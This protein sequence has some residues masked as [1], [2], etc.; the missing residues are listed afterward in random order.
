[1]IGTAPLVAG[2]VLLGTV[3]VGLVVHEWAHAAVLRL[4]GI[5]YDVSFFPGHESGPLG[6]LASCPWA[7]VRPNPTD[8]DPAWLLR[9]AALAP[10]LL[11]APVFVVG[12]VGDGWLA[13][14]L[15]TAAAIGWL[16]C[17]L[18]SPQDFSVAFYAHRA[19]EKRTAGVASLPR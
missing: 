5:D 1:M 6:L 10:A 11:S 15:A 12:F 14:P 18:P 9:C 13:S 8:R 3:A 4:G 2:C 7:V 16:A 17:S 19:L